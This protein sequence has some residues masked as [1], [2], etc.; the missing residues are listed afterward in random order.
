LVA[1]RLDQVRAEARMVMLGARWADR[2]RIAWVL[3]YAHLRLG[4]GRA[5]LGWI[6]VGDDAERLVRLRTGA[7]VMARRRDAVPLYE[8]FA[9]D[10]YGVELPFAVSRVLDL[11]ANVGFA[12]VALAARFPGARFAC[13]EPDAESRRLLAANVERNGVEAIVIGAAVAG[14]AGRRYHVAAGVAPGSN[15]VV[16]AGDGSVDGL[17]VAELLDRAGL[18]QADLMKIDVEGGEWGVFENAGEWAGRVR[19]VIGELHPVSDASDARADALL[20]PHGFERV[21]LPETLR[22]NDVCCW[23]RRG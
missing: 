8:Q 5:V 21:A 22:F 12:T 3:S 20:A 1:W 11:G 13:V 16:A 15:T 10:V 17:T 14:V 23:I 7:G 2:L 4:R 18:D 6:P 19:A 9:L